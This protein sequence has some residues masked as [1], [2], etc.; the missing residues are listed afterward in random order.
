MMK[1]K[2][3]HDGHCLHLKVM[4]CLMAEIN[5]CY[6]VND[7][8]DISGSGACPRDPLYGLVITFFG[9]GYV[10]SSKYWLY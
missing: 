2:I 5:Y 9:G 10:F 4:V 1:Q 3:D 8:A 6:L 7:N